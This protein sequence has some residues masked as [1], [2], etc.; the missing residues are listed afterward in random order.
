MQ[1]RKNPQWR[2][3]WVDHGNGPRPEILHAN[4]F[5]SVGVMDPSDGGGEVLKI[6][7]I[8]YDPTT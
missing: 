3:M 1:E 8:K 7:E 2:I 6:E 5:V 4:C